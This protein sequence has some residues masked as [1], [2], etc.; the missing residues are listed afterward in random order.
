MS[1]SAARKARIGEVFSKKTEGFCK[2]QRRRF[3][4]FAENNPCGLCR[5]PCPRGA[6][7]PPI[8]LQTEGDIAVFQIINYKAAILPIEQYAHIA[9]TRPQRETLLRNPIAS[10]HYKQIKQALCIALNFYL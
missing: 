8:A 3:G 7:T 1:P 4:K 6:R 10:Q 2:N 9:L 5:H